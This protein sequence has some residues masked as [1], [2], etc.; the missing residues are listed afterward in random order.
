MAPSRNADK[1][2]NPCVPNLKFNEGSAPQWNSSFLIVGFA[3]KLN[4]YSCTHDTFEARFTNCRICIWIWATICVYNIKSYLPSYGILPF[5]T[6]SCAGDTVPAP[7]PA[8]NGSQWYCQWWWCPSGKPKPVLKRLL[9][10]TEVVQRKFVEP[11]TTAFTPELSHL[12]K[13]FNAMTSISSSI[14]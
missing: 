1:T 10:A 7:W 5:S 13:S 11:E 6:K 4:Q 9:D 14:S 2:V 3:W 12:L 8:A